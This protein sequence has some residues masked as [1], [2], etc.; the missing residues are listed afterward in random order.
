MSE[1]GGFEGFGGSITNPEDFYDP[2]NIYPSGARA[3][4]I[5]L[6]F[7]LPEAQ[8]HVTLPT[9]AKTLKRI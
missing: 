7:T 3:V 5:V 6:I 4:L 8:T 1:Y 2:S 9:K